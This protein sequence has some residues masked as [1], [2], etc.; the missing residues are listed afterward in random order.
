MC[1]LLPLGQRIGVTRID[2]CEFRAID[3]KLP[4]STNATL[5]IDQEAMRDLE[6][7]GSEA[8]LRVEIL[9]RAVDPEKEILVEIL[10]AIRGVRPPEEVGECTPFVPSEELIEC[11]GVA[12]DVALHEAFIRKL[13]EI[14]PRFRIDHT[15][16]VP[17]R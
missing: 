12:I 17:I 15:D 10:C 9:A 3:R 14:L 2:D 6:E 16:G 4:S 1:E 11:R 7:P 5:V 13:A 8:A